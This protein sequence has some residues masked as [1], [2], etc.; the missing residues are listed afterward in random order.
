MLQKT[1]HFMRQA[2][3]INGEW[4]QADS[5]QTVDV[6]NPATGLKIGTVPKSGKAETA[7]PSKPPMKPS[8]PG[9]RRPRSSARSCCASCTMR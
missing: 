9:A 7:V 4:V 6:N 3:L 1:S 2:N 8:R 5:G